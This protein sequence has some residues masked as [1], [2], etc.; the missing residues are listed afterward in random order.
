MYQIPFR[1]LNTHPLAMSSPRPVALGPAFLSIT[2][3]PHPIYLLSVSNPLL[4]SFFAALLLL[5]LASWHG[6]VYP[7]VF[8]PLRHLPEPVV[9]V[10]SLSLMMSNGF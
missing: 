5:A 2:L 6:I 9:C 3:S 7:K 8:S 1:S 4:A 10:G